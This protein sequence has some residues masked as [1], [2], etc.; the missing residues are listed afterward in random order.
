L[1]EDRTTV[2]NRYVQRTKQ[3]GQIACPTCGSGKKGTRNLLE[4]E[5][6]INRNVYGSCTWLD[7]QEWPRIDVDPRNHRWVPRHR[8][9]PPEKFPWD[10][11]AQMVI[12]GL[13]GKGIPNTKE[14]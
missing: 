8:G 10:D 4:S 9:K 7:C 13:E 6:T 11:G 5:C 2:A 14:D 3:P 12:P 1:P